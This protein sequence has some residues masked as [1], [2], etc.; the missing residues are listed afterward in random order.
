MG[1]AVWLAVPLA[2]TLLA[3]LWTWSRGRPGRQPGTRRA[4]QQHQDYLAALTGPARGGARV[5]PPGAEPSDA[6]ITEL[7]G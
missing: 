6:A 2:T 7:R 4:I 1:W 3:C 5:E